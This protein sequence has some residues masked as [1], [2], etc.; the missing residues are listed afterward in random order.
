MNDLSPSIVLYNIGQLITMKNHSQRPKIGK[1]LDSI[2]INDANTIAIKDK[3]IIFIGNRQDFEKNYH[4]NLINPNPNKIKAIDVQGKVVMPGF[5]DSHTHLVFGGSRE[6]E[7]Q[8]KLQGYSYLDILKQGGGI[9]STVEATR[10]ATEEQLFDKARSYA[11]DMIKHGTTTIEI[12][13]GYGLDQET[14]LKILR[15]AHE[16]KKALPVNIVSTYLGAHTLPKD[17]KDNRE[18]YITQVI[19]TLPIA[20]DYAVFCDV[21]CEDGAFTVEETRR[22]FL[23][24]E[25]FGYKLKIHAGQFN[26]L[27]GDVLAGEMK[28][29]SADHLDVLTDEGIERMKEAGVIGV[30]LPGVPFHLMTGVYA[31]L[32]K[33]VEMGLP[34][35][36]ATDF[37]PGSCPCYNM[38]EILNIACRKQKVS[39]N[40]ALSMST[41]NAAHAIN[42]ADITGSIEIG[43][44]ADIAI[45]DCFDYKTMFY[46]YGVNHIQ[47]TIANGYIFN[48]VK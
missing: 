46:H 8:M 47:T 4:I 44:Q 35:A 3:E 28:A 24:A 12:K 22:I 43:K 41:I 2:N 40:E 39:M 23:E 48:N 19:D 33:M 5:V 18:E 36:I 15:V 1:E 34:V 14:E 16:L 27:G 37:N 25:K 29:I 13:S 9:L 26:A 6:N 7:F 17:Y 45:L 32:R 38:Q 21:F 31:P 30:A 11:L 42:L 10:K 20:K